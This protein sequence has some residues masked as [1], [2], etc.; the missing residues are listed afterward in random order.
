[1]QVGELAALRNDI[2][3]L[4]PDTCD[5]LSVTRTADGYGGFGETWGTASAAVACRMDHKTGAE[6]LA[7]GA[8]QTY[9]GNMLTL[10][11]NATIT[12]AN[13]VKF[14]G[15]NYNVLAVSEGSDI[16]VKRITVERV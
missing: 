5:I 1:M 9:Q 13:R 4:L 11:Y 12:T 14:S 6:Q 8:V 3:A 2:L 16:A 15:N 10:P 7:G